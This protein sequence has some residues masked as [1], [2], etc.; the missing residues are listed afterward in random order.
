MGSRA[1]RVAESQLTHSTE[2]GMQ[3]Q[4]WEGG[5]RDGFGAM[6]E[7]NTPDGEDHGR[8]LLLI[9]SPSSI[10]FIIMSP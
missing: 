3:L 9:P 8:F 2:E 7:M 5:P 4:R 6:G 10:L 1:V